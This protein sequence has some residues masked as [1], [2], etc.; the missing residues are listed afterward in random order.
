MILFMSRNQ[1]ETMIKKNIKI[2]EDKIKQIIAH[3]LEEIQEIKNVKLAIIV[4]FILK[5]WLYFNHLLI[6]LTF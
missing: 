6:H 1:R 3:H 5:L 2:C 4:Y